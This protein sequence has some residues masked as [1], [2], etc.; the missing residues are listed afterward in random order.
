MWMVPGVHRE[1]AAVEAIMRYDLLNERRRKRIGYEN[2][3]PIAYEVFC[4]TLFPGCRLNQDRRKYE[5]T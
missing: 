2:E 4:Q 5:A 3:I 1:R